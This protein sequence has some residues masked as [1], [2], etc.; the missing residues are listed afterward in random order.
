MT[1]EDSISYLLSRAH[2]HSHLRR[3]EQP[4]VPGHAAEGVGGRVHPAL[5]HAVVLRVLP[6]HGGGVHLVGLAAVAFL[7]VERG[8]NFGRFNRLPI[9]WVLWHSPGDKT[10]FFVTF[11][12]N[13]K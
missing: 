3:H 8:G 4:H 12:A 13:L 9:L 11:V 2:R 7:A 1:V 6:E 10:N 5:Q